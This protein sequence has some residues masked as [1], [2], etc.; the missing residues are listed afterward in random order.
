MET[1]RKNNR[2][3]SH[4][5]LEIWFQL[6]EQITHNLTPKIGTFVY[7]VQIIVLLFQHDSYIVNYMKT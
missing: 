4:Q 7:N 3:R 6:V 1:K 2:R 5:K